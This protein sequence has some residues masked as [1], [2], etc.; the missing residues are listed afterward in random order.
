VLGCLRRRLNLVGAGLAAGALDFVLLSKVW[1]AAR[2]PASAVSV[3]VDP[4]VS[5]PVARERRFGGDMDA[6]RKRANL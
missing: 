4:L 1:S 3:A 2:P 5:P 6:S